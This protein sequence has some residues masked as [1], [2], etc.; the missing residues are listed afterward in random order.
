M[1]I[2]LSATDSDVVIKGLEE[3]FG[4]KTDEN[5]EIF[6][7]FVKIIRSF[8]TKGYILKIS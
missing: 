2:F 6:S 4:K 8:F 3:E 7:F 1:I 5:E